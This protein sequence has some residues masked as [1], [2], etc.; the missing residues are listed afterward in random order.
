LEWVYEKIGIH[1]TC[2]VLNL[3][4]IPGII[5]GIIGAVAAGVANKNVYGDSLN[6]IFAELGNGRSQATQAAYQV[7]CLGSTIGIALI[8]GM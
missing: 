1:D 6:D 8:I 4:G 3:H 5:G 2:G 7:A